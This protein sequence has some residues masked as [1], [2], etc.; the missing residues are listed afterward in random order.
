MNE[1]K[2]AQVCN[3]QILFE[4]IQTFK[5]FFRKYFKLHEYLKFKANVFYNL[6]ALQLFF[7]NFIDIF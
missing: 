4:R 6:E 5:N 2:D 7:K 3:M 1:F